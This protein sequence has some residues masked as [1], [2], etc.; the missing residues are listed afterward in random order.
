MAGITH[1]ANPSKQLLTLFFLRNGEASAPFR[2]LVMIESHS[3]KATSRRKRAV[4]GLHLQA[5]AMLTR[6]SADPH[7]YRFHFK[8]KW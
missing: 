4:T 2:R 3:V 7:S 8:R 1:S 5:V 6:Q